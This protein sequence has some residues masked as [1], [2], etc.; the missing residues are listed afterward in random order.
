MENM[1]DEEI[2]RLIEE[3]LKAHRLKDT[4]EKDDDAALYQ[5]LFAELEKHPLQNT[6]SELADRI[7]REIELKLDKAERFYYGMLI[8]AFLIFFSALMYGAFV[9]TN[10][11]LSGQIAHFLIANK[12]ICFFIVLAFCTIQV[13]DQLI[14][15]RKIKKYVRRI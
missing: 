3:Q 10:D 14:E 6:N 13:V 1:D 2:Q 11:A 9:S 7:V 5:V 4:P 8:F 12:S 15:L